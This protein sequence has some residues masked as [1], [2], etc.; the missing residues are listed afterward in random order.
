MFR[1]NKLGLAIV[2]ALKLYT[3][4]AKGLKLKVRKFWKLIPTF[5]EV[6]WEK[7]VG[8]AYCP[9]P[10]LDRVYDNYFLKG[11]LKTLMIPPNKFFEQVTLQFLLISRILWWFFQSNIFKFNLTFNV[12][13]GVS[14]LTTFNIISILFH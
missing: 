2:M 13:L 1:F 7:L 11:K 12:L 4:V 8:G 9:L 10:I 14:I 6:A 5:V 3:S